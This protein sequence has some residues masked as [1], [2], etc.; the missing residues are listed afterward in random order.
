MLR[1]TLFFLTTAW[2]FLLFSS[3]YL[4]PI[5]AVMIAPTQLYRRSEVELNPL[6]DESL[7]PGTKVT[8][9]DVNEEG[10]WLKIRTLQGTVG[11]VPFQVIRII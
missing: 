3:Y 11:Y 5:E 1:L 4:T 2:S 9:L 8:I 7:Q 10:K 6:I